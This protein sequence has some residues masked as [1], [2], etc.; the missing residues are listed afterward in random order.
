MC[1]LNSDPMWGW[2]GAF[3]CD[4]GINGNYSL[5]IY[6]LTIIKPFVYALVTLYIYL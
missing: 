1:L 4:W 5:L 6:T 3:Q 2:G